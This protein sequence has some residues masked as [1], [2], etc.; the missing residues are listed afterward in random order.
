MLGFG[1]KGNPEWGLAQ[2]EHD[3]HLDL[4]HLDGL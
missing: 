2:V 1:K 3:G 4:R